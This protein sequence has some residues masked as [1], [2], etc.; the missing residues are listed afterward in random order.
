MY[1]TKEVEIS[2]P[3]IAFSELLEGLTFSV[4]ERFVYTI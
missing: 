2:G 4:K 1:L 3:K